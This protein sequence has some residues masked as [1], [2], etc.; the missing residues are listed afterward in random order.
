MNK[1][2]EKD[3]DD[4]QMKMTDEEDRYEEDIDAVDHIWIPQMKKTQ[5][6]KTTNE[7]HR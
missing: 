1:T 7:D 2:D 5:M 6:K 4:G 3:R